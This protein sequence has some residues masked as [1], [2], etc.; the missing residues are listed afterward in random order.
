VMDNLTR[1]AIDERLRVLE[2]VSGAVFRCIDDLLRMRSVLPA[3]APAMASPHP[4][5]SSQPRNQEIPS[6]TSAV[7]S[8]SVSVDEELP[9]SK[10][11]I[12]DDLATKNA[13]TDED[14]P[15]GQP[16]VADSS[17]TKLDEKHAPV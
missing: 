11:Q 9:P 13:G 12:I 8:P 14:N 5:T 7:D 4:N 16:T 10:S 3:H 6:N 1:A 2:G 17:T 15:T